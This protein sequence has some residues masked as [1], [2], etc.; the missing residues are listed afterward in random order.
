MCQW[1]K[2]TPGLSLD[3]RAR[4]QV[5]R[6]CVV[7]KGHRVRLKEWAE[8]HVV[9]VLDGQGD[10]E[11]P[12]WVNCIDKG[13]RC[14]DI[15]MRAGISELALSERARVLPLG[16]FGRL[17]NVIRKGARR[18][19][20]L[21][22]RASGLSEEE[23][24][25]A[26]EQGR[27]DDF[28][29]ERMQEVTW[30]LSPGAE[31]STA[32]IVARHRNHWGV[33]VLDMV[34]RHAQ[35][36]DSLGF[37]APPNLLEIA[38]LLVAW[39]RQEPRE[40]WRIREANHIL[41]DI[42]LDRQRDRHSCGFC[43]LAALA[44]TAKSRGR[45]PNEGYERHSARTKEMWRSSVARSWMAS[46]ESAH[47]LLGEIPTGSSVNIWLEQNRIRRVG[48]SP[49]QGSNPTAVVSI[50][51]HLDSD[52]TRARE[53]PGEQ[54]SAKQGPEEPESIAMSQTP[55][56]A[57]EEIAGGPMTLLQQLC[58]GPR[59]SGIKEW[60]EG[61]ARATGARHVVER[62]KPMKQECE[63]KVY[64]YCRKKAPRHKS[65]RNSLA[66]QHSLRAR[67]EEPRPSRFVA[68]KLTGCDI[69]DIRWKDKAHNHELMP[70][71]DRLERPADEAGEDMKARA[72]SEE[73]AAAIV[74]LAEKSDCDNADSLV[75]KLKGISEGFGR[76][77][78]RRATAKGPHGPMA[79]AT[80]DCADKSCQLKIRIRTE[81]VPKSG[82]KEPKA[83]F[84][85]LQHNHP[86][87]PSSARMKFL[88]KELMKEAE[89]MR[90]MSFQTMPNILR[91][92]E[93][94]HN[95]RIDPKTLKNKIQHRRLCCA[96]T[97]RDCIDF[98]SGL[99]DMKDKHSDLFY[100]YKTDADLKLT[101][102]VFALPE[103]MRNC[104]LCGHIAVAM[105]GKAIAT[106]H[107]MPIITIGARGPDG[108]LQ[109]HFIAVVIDETKD[110]F[111]WALEQLERCHGRK[112]QVI[113]I[114]QGAAAAPTIRE[115]WSSAALLRDEY[116]LNLSQATR[117]GAK[118]EESME[119]LEL[120]RSPAEQHFIARS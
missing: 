104:K 57:D 30:S 36:G 107:Q 51:S 35:W 11:D 8:R 110:A 27:A 82:V 72:D 118:T 71:H 14:I 90:I 95:V 32:F 105:D 34:R 80:I 106:Q 6:I 28:G 7:L 24:R 94:T 54:A 33:L 120:R 81:A 31:L 79:R 38:I 78:R 16:A 84:I 1:S 102:A 119:M 88:P 113:F 92:L 96:A 100:D 40:M 50:S 83:T 69:W 44:T 46:V 87:G 60:L 3:P 91:A 70:E 85:H 55:A 61:L 109:A 59:V 98:L 5:K 115:M 67:V 4:R 37:R 39:R 68:R 114:D 76:K 2:K 23:K 111:R 73:R 112:P 108:A 13:T 74:A 77:L 41:H 86:R 12:V 22:A 75:D 25:D 93:D 45:L 9:K 65:K 58:G 52:D 116:H 99:K 56:E 66:R 53:A 20:E 26:L 103:W 17:Q 21:E 47:D 42:G 117:F 19:E 49:H 43:I 64:Y 18:T 10:S 62:A 101:H 48:G 97:E 63:K 15:M 29:A 89:D